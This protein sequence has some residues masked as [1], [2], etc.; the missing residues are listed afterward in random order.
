MGD[1]ETDENNYAPVVNRVSLR[2][3]LAAVAHKKWDL[4]QADVK[5][6]FLNADNPGMEY[7]RLPK[8][9]VECEQARVCILKKALYGLQRAPKMWHLTFSS[10]AV[11]IG[12]YQS[13][14][15]PCLFMH[16]TK[17]QLIIIYVDD[18]LLAAG[19]AHLMKELCDELLARFQCT[20]MGTPTYFLGMNLE[21]DRVRGVVHLSQRTYIDAIVEKY[22]LA[23]AIPRTLP[24]QPG[25][26]LVKR[27]DNSDNLFSEYGSLVGALL[28][29]AVCTRPDISFAVGSLTKFVSKPGLEH[30]RAAVDLTRYL[31]GSRTNGISLGNTLDSSLCG[32]ADSDWGSDV[33]DRISVSGGINFW[34]PMFFLGFL[35]SNPWCTAEAESHAMVDVGK[36]IV[37]VQRVVGDIVHFLGEPSMSVPRMY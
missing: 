11:D 18:M 13:E 1:S 6:A 7:V 20:I 26:V 4:V 16:A 31:K 17:K 5:T 36:E 24:M 37:H 35:A 25:L 27:E 23:T 34:D 19:D 15:D 12:F 9:V 28:F 14:H 33:N 10:W 2:T 3:F 29:L 30:W 32:Y 22:G 21:Y 8:E